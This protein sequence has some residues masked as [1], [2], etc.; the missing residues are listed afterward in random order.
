MMSF[1]LTEYLSDDKTT[2]DLSGTAIT[3]AGLKA[4]RAARPECEFYT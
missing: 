2:L 1:N 3:D 4:F